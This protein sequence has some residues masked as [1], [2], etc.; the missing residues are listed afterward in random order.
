MK[1]IEALDQEAARPDFWNDNE[2]AQKVL[3]KR[4]HCQRPVELWRSLNQQNEDVETLI[5]LS[6]EESDDSLEVDIRLALE[7][8]ISELERAELQAMLSGEN[9]ANNAILAINS[10]WRANCSHRALQLPSCAS[11]TVDTTPTGTRSADMLPCCA[12]STR[13]SGHF[14]A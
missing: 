13:P 7:T 14:G 8:L 10:D 12:T 3:Q 2:A 1:E 9:D 11:D 6:E 5:A 4:A